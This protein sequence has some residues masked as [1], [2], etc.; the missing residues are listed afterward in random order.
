LS[1]CFQIQNSFKQEDALS[2]LLFNFA[3]EYAIRKVHEIQVGQ[4]LNWTHQ[5]LACADDVNLLGDNTDIMYKNTETLINASKEVHL[6]VNVEE[7]KYMLVSRYQN[8]D[9]NRDNRKEIV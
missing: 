3:L 1:D 9:K 5:L 7:T 4:K 8:A 6:E 2:S